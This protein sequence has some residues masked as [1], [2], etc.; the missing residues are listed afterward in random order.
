MRLRSLTQLLEATRALAHPDRIVILGSSCLLPIYPGLGEPGQPLE[1]SYDSDLLLTPIDDETAA[2]LGEAVGQQS[3][4]AKRHGYYADVLRPSIAE[5]L[6]AGWE[7]RL[8]LVAGCDNVFALDVYDLALVKLMIGR[9]K[10]L[11]LLRALLKL[12]VLEPMRLRAHYQQTPLGD[13]EAGTAGRNLT[14]LLR[15]AGTG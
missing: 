13:R 9:Q 5:T 10:D 8:H 11:D 2:I 7:S 3:L 1:M 12:G 4:F 14:V 6:P 15:E